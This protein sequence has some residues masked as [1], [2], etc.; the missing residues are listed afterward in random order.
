MNI[1]FQSTEIQMSE[2]V[3]SVKEDRIALMQYAKHEIP[4]FI[5]IAYL[6]SDVCSLPSEHRPCQP[7]NVITKWFFN[8]LTK[9]CEDFSDRGCEGNKNKFDS[10]MQCQASCGGNFLIKYNSQLHTFISN[11]L[12]PSSLEIYTSNNYYGL[13]CVCK[14]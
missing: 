6:P 8:T 7:Y 5:F 11:Y 12:Y 13:S 10:K 1:Q 9:S 3:V 14:L 2:T 4:L